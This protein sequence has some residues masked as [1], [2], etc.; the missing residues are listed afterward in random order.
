MNDY[1]FELL[2]DQEIPL[3]MALDSDIFTTE[4]LQE[5][6]MKSLNAT[7]MARR[8]FRD[9]AR[10]SGLVFQGYPGKPVKAKHLQSNSQLFFDVFSE[11][12]PNH[13]LLKQ[14]YEEVLDFE[15]EQ[16]R[17]RKALN[18]INRQQI[19]I[20]KPE[21]PSPFAFPILVDRLREKYTNEKLEDRVKKMLAQMGELE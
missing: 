5:D 14:A 3:E 16:V 8:K 17:L 9:I 12:E 20:A 10:I 21:K 7:E 15:L 4:H 1:G 18:R 6:L 11:H 13:V 19:I 2:S